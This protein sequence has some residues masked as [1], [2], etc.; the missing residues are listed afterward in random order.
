M[1][2]T[3]VLEDNR[4]FFSKQPFWE[5]TRERK[6]TFLHVEDQDVRMVRYRLKEDAGG[7]ECIPG[8]GQVSISFSVQE[9]E[10]K[11]CLYGVLPEKKKL[12][13][14]GISQ[15]MMLQFSP[16]GFTR[17]TGIPAADITAE[18]ISLDDVFSWSAP[19]IEAVNSVDSEEEHLRLMEK[20]LHECLEKKSVTGIREKELACAIVE[21]LMRRRQVVKMKELE[22]ESGFCARTLQKTVVSNVGLTPKQLNLQICFQHAIHQLEQEPKYSLTDLAYQMQ[23]YDQSHFGNMFRKMTGLCPGQYQKLLQQ[24]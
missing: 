9:K 4:F 12:E 20:F 2:N 18:G 16:A 1:A 8:V 3:K 17:L 21:Y 22:K 19:Y 11:A 13:H 14:H 15:S 6:D 23:F 5:I 7:L 24:R 10:A